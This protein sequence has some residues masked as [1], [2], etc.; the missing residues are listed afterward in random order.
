MA[1]LGLQAAGM[2]PGA[3]VVAVGQ[4]GTEDHWGPLGTTGNHWEPRCS[5]HF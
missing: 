5:L 3:F 2:D 1:G 4:G